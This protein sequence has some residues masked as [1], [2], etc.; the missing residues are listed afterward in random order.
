MKLEPQKYIN[1][2]QF[3][4]KYRQLFKNLQYPYEAEVKFVIFPKRAS[5][6][7]MSYLILFSLKSIPFRMKPGPRRAGTLFYQSFMRRI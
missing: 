4:T 3:P 1:I 6:S 2:K 5:A 7:L